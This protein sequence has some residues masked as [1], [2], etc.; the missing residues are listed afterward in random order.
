MVDIGPVTSGLDRDRT[1]GWV[2]AKGSRRGG[3]I[4]AEAASAEAAFF[5]DDKID[6]AIAADLQNIFILADI[7]VGLTVLDIGSETAE[8]GEDGLLGFGVL[9]NLARQGE[10][11]Q[12]L[13]Q[14]DI[15][16][17]HRLWHGRALRLVAFAKLDISAEASI[18]N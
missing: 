9:R 17:L 7:G 13:F 5:R 18:A 4:I 6:R 16:G 3:C 11:F 10:K 1:T 8:P 12:R 14:R 15:G 2:I